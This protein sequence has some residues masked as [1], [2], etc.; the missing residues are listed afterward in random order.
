MHSGDIQVQYANKKQNLNPVMVNVQ[1]A[2]DRQCAGLDWRGGWR[3]E[4]SRL[5][6]SDRLRERNQTLK[7]KFMMSPS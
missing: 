2:L 1:V 5:D 6:G 4:R 3:P 7:R